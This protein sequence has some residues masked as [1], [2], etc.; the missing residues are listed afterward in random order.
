ME[1]RP[2]DVFVTAVVSLGL[3]DMA[4]TNK[5]FEEKE[6]DKRL[7]LY[8]NSEISEKYL[9]KNRPSHI[10]DFIIMMDKH[11]NNRWDKI[12]NSLKTN[13]PVE[14]V[15]SQASGQDMY[16]LAKTNNGIEQIQMF[17]H[18]MYGISVGPAMMLPKVFDFSIHNRMMDFGG[19]S[20]VYSIQLA[21]SNPDIPAVVMDLEPVCNVASQYIRDYDLQDGIQTKVIDFLTSNDFSKDCDVALL[22]HIIHFLGEENGKLPLKKIYDSLIDNG[23]SIVLISGW[24]LN[25]EK[26]GHIPSALMSLNMIVDQP[27]G[28]TYS[29]PE[30]SKM[31]T[32]VGFTNIEK[33]SLAGPAEIVIG[34]KKGLDH[35]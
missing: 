29:F 19:G 13:K 28:R 3:L 15:Q 21:K 24:L 14:V 35:I 9:N 20:G 31:L 16:D 5:E 23:D 33:K 7:L 2:A 27:E 32:D 11:L 17:T 26:T 10:G 30:V 4:V 22:S 1:K 25:S 34:Y 8:S 12:G 18:S 6:S